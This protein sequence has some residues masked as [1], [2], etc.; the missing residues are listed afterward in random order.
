MDAL[1]VRVEARPDAPPERRV[2][3]AAELVQA[4]KD[5]V[6]V[7]VTCEVVDPDTVERSV[8][9]LHRLRDRRTT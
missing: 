8:G 6:G 5:T 2:S 3:A 7:T 4:V 9:K 1:T